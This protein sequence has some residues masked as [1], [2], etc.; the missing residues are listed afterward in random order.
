MSRK[1][2][3]RM[4]AY[5][6]ASDSWLYHSVTVNRNVDL[7]SNAERSRCRPDQRQVV[8][9]RLHTTENACHV[10]HHAYGAA[11]SCSSAVALAC[12]RPRLSARVA[13]AIPISSTIPPATWSGWRR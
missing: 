9:C 13:T 4:W 11:I 2:L 10:F 3:G 12:F 5:R 7:R 6:H 8:G 1:Q